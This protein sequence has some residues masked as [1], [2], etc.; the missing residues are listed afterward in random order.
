VGYGYAIY[1]GGKQLAIGHGSIND[2]SHVFDAGVIGACKALEHTISMP[3]AVSNKRLW[4][5]IDN[6]GDKGR[7]FY[8]FTMGLPQVP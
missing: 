3:S 1:Q 4:M 8:L 7:P 2:M 6:L 5:C